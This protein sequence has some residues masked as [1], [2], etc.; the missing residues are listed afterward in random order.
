MRMDKSKLNFIEIC[1]VLLCVSVIFSVSLVG[2][3]DACVFTL[4]VAA[5]IL[6]CA[7]CV[8]FE[9]LENAVIKRF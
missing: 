9:L 6:I 5:N 3:K 4:L 1:G 8:F 7:V 2:D